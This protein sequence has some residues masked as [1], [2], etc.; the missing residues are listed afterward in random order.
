MNEPSNTSQ[1][2]VQAAERTFLQQ[3][4]SRVS[5]D[6]LAREL[7]MSKKTLYAH[8]SGK[9]ALLRAMIERRLAVA[10][11][12]LSGI[13]SA[14]LPFPE[15]LRQLMHLVHGKV[16][17][18]SPVFLEDI[19]RYAPGVFSIVEEFRGRALPLYFGRLLMEGVESGYLRR[20]LPPQLVVRVLVLSIQ[21]IVRPEV[22]DDFKL[23]PSAALDA[24]LAILFKGILT[25]EGRKV[26]E[27]A[28]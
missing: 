11:A 27:E 24:V 22:I 19:R 25:D 21:G 26:L 15:K 8:Y 5:M 9:E 20:E 4:F 14:D 16:A 10:E 23:H 7:G 28:A 2:I 1:R 18:T 6:D 3:G 13:V 12:E 17:E